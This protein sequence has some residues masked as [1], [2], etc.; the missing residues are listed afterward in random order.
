[1]SM[2]CCYVVSTITFFT[3]VVYTESGLKVEKSRKITDTMNGNILTNWYSTGTVI[4]VNFVDTC[5][6]IINF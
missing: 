4:L 2:V 5:I 6:F 1:M 3:S